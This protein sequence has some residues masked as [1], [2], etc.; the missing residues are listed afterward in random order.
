[1]LH[2]IWHY[3]NG[4]DLSRCICFFILFRSCN[5]GYSSGFLLWRYR[6]FFTWIGFC[7]SM[8]HRLWLYGSRLNIFILSRFVDLFLCF[9]FCSDSSSLL[10]NH[11]GS[12]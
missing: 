6:C 2:G 7:T 3:G 12:C 10:K 11:R 1:M 8:L 5:Q 9:W 4:F